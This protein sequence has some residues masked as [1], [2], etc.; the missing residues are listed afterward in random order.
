MRIFEVS[1][2]GRKFVGSQD[3][4]LQDVLAGLPLIIFCA[5]AFL[6]FAIQIVQQW[7]G[8]GI[9][10][11]LQIISEGMAACFMAMQIVLTCI[12]RLPIRKSPGLAPRLIAIAAANFSYAIALL[13]H[14]SLSARMSVISSVLL[15]V[16]TAGSVITLAWLGRGFS[17][18]PQARRLA[19][20]GPYRIVRH[21]LYMCEQI[22]VFGASLH[23]LQPWGLLIAG[24]GLCLQ[25][26]RMN[27]EEKVLGEVFPAYKSYAVV[28]PQ[29]FP[30]LRFRSMRKAPPP[31]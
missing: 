22:S 10:N 5:I 24:I 27:Y 12:R 21:P 17:I 3:T 4:R 16:G 25:F 23:Y 13:P 15:L 30:G 26:P 8:Q 2:K 1:S 14:V 18:L 9:L 7:F 20:N 31:S 29:W 19:L 6:G 28:T 11:L